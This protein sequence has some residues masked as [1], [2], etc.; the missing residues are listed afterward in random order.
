[1]RKIMIEV[2]Q[3]NLESYIS[4]FEL[5]LGK[6]F[7]DDANNYIENNNVGIKNCTDKKV[8]PF[9]KYWN[10]YI[11]DIK[12]TKEH[13]KLHISRDTVFILELLSNIKDIK[14]KKNISRIIHSLLQHNTFYSAVF[15]S[16]I[17]A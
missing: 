17:L 12:N 10:S 9:Y 13:N 1:M 7:I 8:H 2:N 3:N 11:N 15:E 14:N 6:S 4:D 16:Q 5:F